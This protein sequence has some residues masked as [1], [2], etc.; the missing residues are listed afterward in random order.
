MSALSILKIAQDILAGRPT[1]AKAEGEDPDRVDPRAAAGDGAG[2]GDGDADDKLKQAQQ[3]AQAAGAAAGAQGGAPGEGGQPGAA[4]EGGGQGPGGDGD[5][6]EGGKGSGDGNGDEEQPVAK[7]QILDS[8][9]FMADTYGISRDEVVKA[10]TPL[11]GPIHGDQPIGRGVELLEEI[12]EGHKSL[13]KIL[14]AIA[15]AISDLT[16][17]QVGL[18]GEVTKALQ[19]ATEAQ[20]ASEK[21]NQTLGGLLRVAPPALA[22]AKDPAEIAKA[23]GSD[24]SDGGAQPLTTSD[25][26]KLALDGKMG[27]LEVASANRRINYGKQ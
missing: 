22:K 1:V 9:R 26:F 20:A 18:S 24:G 5:G 25:L 11:E 6:D 17:H 21:I 2:A 12:V 4:D 14:D 23:Q 8:M 10:F 3:E 7:A 13:G 19:T 27:A 16:K 15:A